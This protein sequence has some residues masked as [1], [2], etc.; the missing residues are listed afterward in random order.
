MTKSTIALAI[1]F[2]LAGASGAVAAPKHVVHHQGAT[3]H[4]TAAA[5]SFGS[6]RVAAPQPT[7]IRIQDQDYRNWN[8]G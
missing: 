1:A 3:V 2:G 4:S 5:Q 6:T 8:G 7:Y